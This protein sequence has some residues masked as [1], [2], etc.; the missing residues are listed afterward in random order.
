MVAA[1]L[2]GALNRYQADKRL[3]IEF[4]RALEVKVA[5]EQPVNSTKPEYDDYHEALNEVVVRL[6]VP[7]T[8]ICRGEDSTD[9]E[10]KC[11]LLGYTAAYQAKL[12]TGADIPT[13]SWNTFKRSVENRILTLLDESPHK[14]GAVTQPDGSVELV[15]YASRFRTHTNNLE[16]I[17]DSNRNANF[18]MVNLPPLL[19]YFSIDQDAADPEEI[20]A[21]DKHLGWSVGLCARVVV[22]DVQRVFS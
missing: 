1:L 18:G 14:S 13:V 19:S 16:N 12:L 20:A 2:Q 4:L 5:E 9:I 6:R 10:V 15:S 7:M 22:P 21:L 11:E 3:G 17:I 8:A